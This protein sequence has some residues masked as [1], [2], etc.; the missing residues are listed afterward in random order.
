MFNIEACHCSS[1]TQCNIDHTILTMPILNK[2]L[3]IEDSYTIAHDYFTKTTHN[4]RHCLDA[5]MRSTLTTWM[6]EVCE[7]EQCTNDVF[8]LAV[9]I[10]DRFM[11]SLLSQSQMNVEKYHLQL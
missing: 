10:F 2:M 11:C 1:M 9:N 6:L 3:H 5:S 8:S 7:E 4:N